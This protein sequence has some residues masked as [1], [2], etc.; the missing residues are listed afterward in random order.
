MLEIQY[1]TNE[2]LYKDDLMTILTFN[3][4]TGYTTVLLSAITVLV[5]AS[6]STSGTAAKT[7]ERCI[8][9]GSQCAINITFTPEKS[10]CV[11]QSQ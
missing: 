9:N 6:R 2:F 8:S 5:A 11:F 10:D 7:P 4:S 1:E 3:G